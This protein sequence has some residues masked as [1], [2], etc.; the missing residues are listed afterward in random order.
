[1]NSNQSLPKE[2]W[3]DD[4][5]VLPV[6]DESLAAPSR[7]GA[8]YQVSGDDVLQLFDAPSVRRVG[9][10]VSGLLNAAATAETSKVAQL[11]EYQKSPAD[12]PPARQVAGEYIAPPPTHPSQRSQGRKATA[13][14]DYYK[15]LAEL[16]QMNLEFGR[17][18]RAARNE[19]RTEVNGNNGNGNGYANPELVNGNTHAQAFETR[20]QTGRRELTHPLTTSFHVATKRGE[21]RPVSAQ[22]SVKQP[23]PH[24][25]PAHQQRVTAKLDYNRLLEFQRRYEETQPHAPTIEDRLANNLTQRQAADFARETVRLAEPLRPRLP[26]REVEPRQALPEMRDWQNTANHEAVVRRQQAEQDLQRHAAPVL[27]PQTGGL[28]RS[29]PEQLA[30]QLRQPV[31]R[32]R[33]VLLDPTRIDPHLIALSDF[34]PRA[35]RYFD[36][37]AVSLISVSYKRLCKRVLLASALPG[38][39]RTCVALNLAGALARARQRVL[40][41]DCDLANPSVLRL[42]GIDAPLGLSEA[43][44]RGL[45]PNSAAL[46]VQPAGFNI[47]PTREKVQHTAELLAAPRF[48][49]MLQM[50]EPDYDFILFDSSPL[51]ESADANLLAGLT[52]ATMLVIRPGMTT[53]QQM[54]K[55]V[56]LFNEKDIC[57][58]VLNRVAK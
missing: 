29:T 35:A 3:A 20:Q 21:A 15:K 31:E 11:N 58:V 37:V 53:T 12:G 18:I 41:V 38:E 14:L 56:S 22:P 33:E 7:N 49:E 57:G 30:A 2:F 4:E 24:P 16:Q 32:V 45:G 50:C 19:A 23:T 13:K 39:G 5:N 43:V 17:S 8:S 54:A 55:A 28:R 10:K 6:L 44:H 9:N 26:V 46:R 42:L 25:L 40:V 52:D 36:Q 34:N 51:L 1:M 48:H 27:T 47:L